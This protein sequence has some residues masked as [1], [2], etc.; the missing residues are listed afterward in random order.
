M[1]AACDVF[2]LLGSTYKQADLMVSASY[3]EIYSG[4]VC[5]AFVINAA[6]RN[7]F[8]V[9]FFCRLFPLSLPSLSYSHQFR[10]LSRLFP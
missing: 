3:F 8:G 1:L 9:G 7:L 4:K 5:L 2:R 6:T 10:V